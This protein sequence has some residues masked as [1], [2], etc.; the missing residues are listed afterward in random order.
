[1]T[2]KTMFSDRMHLSVL[3][4]SLC[5]GGLLLLGAVLPSQADPSLGCD[6]WRDVSL[7]AEKEGCER[8]QISVDAC[9]GRCDTWQIPHL[10]PPFRTSSHTVCTYER[11]E[12]RTTQLQNCQPGVDPTY[13][14]HNAVSCRCAMCH[15]H[16]TS[17]ETLV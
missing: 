17:C 15:A 3:T 14:Y 12:T 10:T 9:K 5:A 1:M 6:V 11:V 2:L 16:N 7:Y 13:V 8:Q 4:F